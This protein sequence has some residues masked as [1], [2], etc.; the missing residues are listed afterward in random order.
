MAR[1]IDL[2][3]N[4]DNAG[5]HETSGPAFLV[6][7]TLRRPHGIHGEMIMELDTD[8]PEHLQPGRTLFLGK[9]HR[10]VTVESIRENNQTVLIKFTGIESPEAV[11]EYRNFTVFI[12]TED[13]P[14]LPDG[15]YYYYQLLGMDVVDENDQPVGVVYDVLQTG[16]NDVYVVHAPDGKEVLIPVIEDVVLKIDGGA[17]KIHVHLPEWA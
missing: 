11:G 10:A 13:L 17:K 6:C 15:E 7:G 4:S 14:P 16:A 12:K 9:D 3:S 5:S 1:S 8:F 2:P